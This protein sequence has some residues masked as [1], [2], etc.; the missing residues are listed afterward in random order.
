VL[1]ASASFGGTIAATRHLGAI[2][3][4][5][6][7]LS[8]QRL[9][10]A[11][12]SRHTAGA[13]SAPPESE[14]QRFLERLLAIGAADPGQ[15][16][17]PTS[18]ETAWLYTQNAA[19]L[20]RYFRAVQPSTAVLQKILD[21]KLFADAA[22][23]AGLAVLPSWD[24]RNIDDV[25]ALAPTLPYPIL[26]KPRTHVH[27][28]RSDKGVVVYSALALINEYRRFVDRERVRSADDPLL[29]DANLPIL[30]QFVRVGREGVHSVT[31]F[32]DQTGELFVTRG[33]TKIFQRSQP[34]GVGVCFESLPPSPAL[35]EAVR[36]LCRELG[37]F[38]IFEVEFLWFDGRWA[39]IDFN[40]RLFSQIGMD[41]RRGMPLPLLACLDAAGETTSLRDAVAKAQTESDEETVFCDRF[42]LRAILLA[43]TVTA[44]I[45]HKDRAYWHG[46]RKQH[47]AHAVD[48]AA[49]GSDPMPGVIHALSELYLG[50][51]S[52]PRFLRSMPRVSSKVPSVLTNGPS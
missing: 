7:V 10:A 38:G 5:V 4:D 39:A 30:Q 13:Y 11:A 23:R 46:W 52:F 17:L 16:L 44:R 37:Y 49:D 18:D 43:K 27:R 25:E 28:L 26:I 48:F 40:P 32:I 29:R 51:K 50:I 2:G 14:S 21:K 8:S 9:A 3:F 22:S 15:I 6:R 19:E 24:P 41:I 1:L 12:W 20:G 35:S 47:A 36:H 31:G 45:S 33:A 42:T 34:V